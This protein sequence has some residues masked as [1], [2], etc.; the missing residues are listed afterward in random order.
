MKIK[1]ISAILAFTMIAT[2]TLAE[3]W[4][5]VSSW[6][7]NDV[8]NFKKEGM[9]PESLDSES[10][11]TKPITRLQLA[12]ILHSAL[13]NVADTSIK[14]I[15][16]SNQFCDTNDESANY[17][18]WR[19]I[20]TGERS[21]E[22]DENG[23]EKPYF[24]PDRLL[25]REEIAVIAD[26]TIE[27]FLGNDMPQK[28]LM[29]ISDISTVSNWAVESVKKMVNA[30]IMSGVGDG[31]FSPKDNLTIEQAISIVYRLYNLMPTGQTADGAGIDANEGTVV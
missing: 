26:R 9:L 8:S 11:F 17:L 31:I 5:T 25:T 14:N 12:Q 27:W 10:D 20:I 2:P 23:I 21:N 24:Y 4:I 22:Y 15:Y 30:G 3:T 7:Y 16:S 28:Q 13:T 1:I 29:E 19:R 18:Y 6:A